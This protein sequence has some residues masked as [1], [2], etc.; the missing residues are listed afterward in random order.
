LW[1]I[2]T[3]TSERFKSLSERA[4]MPSEKESKIT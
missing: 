2:V 1:L 4:L 3:F